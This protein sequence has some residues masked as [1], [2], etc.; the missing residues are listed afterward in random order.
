MEEQPRESMSQNN[1]EQ[2]CQR[3]EKTMF[4]AIEADPNNWEPFRMLAK[5]QVNR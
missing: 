3:I 1:F 5:M 4:N 2:Y